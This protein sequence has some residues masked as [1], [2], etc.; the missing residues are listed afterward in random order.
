MWRDL[1]PSHHVQTESMLYYLIPPVEIIRYFKKNVTKN[2]IIFNFISFSLSC[3]NGML[4]LDE[5][6][7][8]SG[9]IKLGWVIVDMNIFVAN[10]L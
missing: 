2:S 5:G 10:A 7:Q 1:I 8:F 9:V 6:N 4:L 3:C